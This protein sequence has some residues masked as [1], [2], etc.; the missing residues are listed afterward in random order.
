MLAKAY[1]NIGL[2]GVKMTSTLQQ[3]MSEDDPFGAKILPNGRVRFRNWMPSQADRIPEGQ[4]KPSIEFAASGKKLEMTEI[5]GGWYEAETDYDPQDR[6]YR[7]NF[8]SKYDGG[9]WKGT[10][11]P[12][13][14]Q[15]SKDHPGF[16]RVFDPAEITHD[17]APANWHGIKPEEQ[18]T[19]ETH[20]GT[21][22][23]EGTFRAAMDVIPHWADTGFTVV[24]SL[25]IGEAAST[26]GWGYDENLKAVPLPAYG[27]PQDLVDFI[28]ECHAH[29]MGFL[30][31]IVDNHMGPHGGFEDHSPQMESV[32]GEWG[33]K[34]DMSIPEV[35][36]FYMQKNLHWLGLGVDG[37]R[38]DAVQ[39]IH[40][41]PVGERPHYLVALHD[42]LH[43]RAAELG[44][45]IILNAECV[46]NKPSNLADPRDP[47]KSNVRAT[48]QWADDYCH[49]NRALLFAD[50][51]GEGFMDRGYLAPY[52]KDAMAIFAEVQQRGFAL[53]HGEDRNSHRTQADL[54]QKLVPTRSV[55]FISNHD[56]IGN[57]ISGERLE[58][59][60]A[61]D[62]LGEKKMRS[63]L[64]LLL[65]T[66]A[67]TPML[68]QGQE[69]G[70]KNPLFFFANWKK[71]E[72]RGPLVEGRK[73]EFRAFFE[74]AEPTMDFPDP[75]AQATIDICTLD[76]SEA[77]P[78]NKVLMHVKELMQKRKEEIIPHLASGIAKVGVEHSDAH[79]IARYE[80]GDGATFTQGLNIGEQMQWF[81]AQEADAAGTS[82]VANQAFA[83]TPMPQWQVVSRYTPAPAAPA[84]R[85]AVIPV[86]RPV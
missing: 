72:H 56:Q 29:G 55:F 42:M 50:R 40:D 4:G 43:A 10:P 83:A 74:G 41:L 66:P 73:R 62:P 45:T 47:E 32:P 14:Y 60:M 35:N 46:D 61:R 80:F 27:E 2:I 68:Y 33:N 19:V 52:K 15:L 57:L 49:A 12:M 48:G 17:H 44:R 26:Q 18:I 38:Q 58:T 63:A 25:P 24:E 59:A 11:D 36:K 6:D 64:E 84:P 78:D 82:A 28:D 79:F 1:E 3:I 71:E 67:G 75:C 13:S 51:P 34:P 9:G 53:T 77:R 76:L 7:V 22:T 70:A 5:G 54:D 81:P 37:F 20:I 21:L 69:Y 31:D 39:S 16:S 85:A 8:W 86:N 30:L 23:K 65:M